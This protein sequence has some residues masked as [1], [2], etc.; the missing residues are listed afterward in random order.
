MTH[1]RPKNKMKWVRRGI[2]GVFFLAMVLTVGYYFLPLLNGYQTKGML[3]LAGLTGEVTVQ[4]DENGM[5]YIR[6][7]N[8]QDLFF[9]QGF[10]TA[11]DRLF[12]MQL[13]RMMAQGRISELAGEAAL[14]LDRRMRT[15]GLHRMAQKQAQ[16]L[17]EKNAGL[18]QKYVD[19]INAFVDQTAGDIPLE[20]RLAGITPDR[21][22][23]ADSLSIV[24]Y[25]GYA[26]AANLDTEII[27]QMLLETVG[28]EKTRQ[29][30]PLNIHPDDPADRG[31]LD[32]PP[33]PAL[34]LQDSGIL[35]VAAFAKDRKMR[36]G[37]NNWAVASD[38]SESGGA[39]L[40]GDPHLD[41]R[42]LPGVWYPVGLISPGI[43]V[44]GANIPGIPGMVI[45]RTR[46]IALA[47]TNNYGDMQDLYMEQ[48]DP[49]NPD[50]YLEG[51][52]SIAFDIRTETVKI[53]DKNAS[54]GF[55]FQD[56][57]IRSTQ[58]GPIVTDVF[59]GLRTGRPVSLRFAPAESMAADIGLLDILT[60]K[61]TEQLA[62][63]LKQIPMVCLNWV[64]ADI[65]GSIGHQASGKIPIREKGH[66]TFPHPVTD[67]TDNWLGW[68]PEDQMPGALNPD[69]GWVG[70]CNHKTVDS[71]YPYYYSSYFAPRYRYD[72]L[73]ALMNGP[74]KK[75]AGQMWQIQRDVKNPMASAIAPVMADAL[76]RHPDTRYLGE[77]L[78]SWDY[79]DDPAAAAPAVFQAVYTAFAKQV[80]EDELGEK[81]S[82]LLL[83]S[84]YFWQERL[85]QM[86]LDGR[87][88]W[89][90]D[91]RT[92]DRQETMTDL[93]QAAGRE[94]AV[95]LEK[96]LGPDLH[97][98]QWGRIHTLDLVNP[99]ARNGRLKNLLG[100]GPMP[101]GGS[102]ETLY[103]GKYAFG[104]PFDVTHCASM[105]M[106][107]D[108]ADTEKILAVLPGGVSG[109]TFH[110]HQKDQVS[111]FMSGEKRYWR[112]SDAAIDSHAVATLVLVPGN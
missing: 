45:G 89:F 53:R 88:Q 71:D 44:V 21:W 79:M 87:S 77:I 28:Y 67:G 54:D 108:F 95:F 62:D 49:D 91:V 50:H 90:D 2:V 17:N 60:V 81:N 33:E 22:E 98:W 36:A 18:F 13:N 1:Q 39:L 73:K 97:Q 34:F 63:C 78:D 19:G 103:R 96:Q 102:G 82:T 100:T 12:Q 15:I 65:H 14:D 23:I 104:A 20:F 76:R 57:V 68:I 16:M 4:R 6:A 70:T 83:D 86:V 3:D 38:L 29:I 64:F 11:Q 55:A 58:R 59:D 26:T 24:Y 110:P 30:L 48:P 84:W 35:Q 80:F 5:A 93:F 52:R 109:R 56:I 72:R 74:D 31:I 112:F 8:T 69:A 7:K 27:A 66:G 107:V 9:A 105:R 94:A 85:Q 75:S 10:V 92:Q 25:L 47:M 42:V 51:D 111:D 101:M 41:P 106:V 37:S 40:C 99:L 46:H 61:N 43:R 32:I